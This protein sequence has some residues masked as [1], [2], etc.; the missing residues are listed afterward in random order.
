[1]FDLLSNFARSALLNHFEASYLRSKMI[2]VYSS[3]FEL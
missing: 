2:Y 1:M 3:R